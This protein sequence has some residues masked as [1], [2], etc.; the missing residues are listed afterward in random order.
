MLAERILAAMPEMDHP[1]AIESLSIAIS[2]GFGVCRDPRPGCNRAILVIRTL[3]DATPRTANDHVP[4]LVVV[5]LLGSDERH[6]LQETSRV[7]AFFRR[8]A[9]HAGKQPIGFTRTWAPAA[10][11]S[12]AIVPIDGNL[13]ELEAVVTDTRFSNNCYEWFDLAKVEI[14]GVVLRI[15]SGSRLILFQRLGAEQWASV[16]ATVAYDAVDVWGIVQ[17][18][19]VENGGSLELDTVPGSPGTLRDFPPRVDVSGL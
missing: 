18:L 7:A 9:R 17:Q 4:T 8:S 13:P 5:S 14:G 15:D 3:L 12:Y 1:S 6:G 11:D 16:T 19:R 10:I 2:R